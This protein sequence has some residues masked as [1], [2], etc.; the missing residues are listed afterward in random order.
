MNKKRGCF[1]SENYTL[2]RNEKIQ[3][4]FLQF[5]SRWIRQEIFGGDEKYKTLQKYFWHSQ[6]KLELKYY[7]MN[8]TC[9]SIS[10][11]RFLGLILNVVEGIESATLYI[12]KPSS[13]DF[14]PNKHFKRTNYLKPGLWS[15]FSHI[16]YSFWSRPPPVSETDT[17]LKLSSN[18]FKGK[19][20]RFS[21]AIVHIHLQQNIYL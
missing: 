4:L 18:F 17:V 10:S 7:K 20:I 5:S 19:F 21:Y 6:I 11:S 15:P 2:N 8:T 14:T 3:R 9:T 12:T 1:T 13:G 16:Q